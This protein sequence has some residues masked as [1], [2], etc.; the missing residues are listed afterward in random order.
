MSDDIVLSVRGATKVYPGTQALKGVDFDVRRGAV[1]VLVGENGAGKSTLMKIIAGVEQ[2]TEGEIHL[3]GK[4]VSLPDT[5]A[6]SRHGIGIVFQE[7]NLFPN[8]S[9]ADN[10]FIGREKTRLGIDIDGGAQNELARALLARLEHSNSPGTMVGDLRIGEQQI[11][12]IAK[13]LSQDARILILDEPTS[14][15]S[16]TEVEIL[17][18]VI[19]ELKAQGVAIVY[20]SHRLEELVRIGDYITVLRDGRITGARGM[21]DVDVPWIVRAMIGSSS[22]DFAKV[23]EHDYGPEILR[24]EDMTLP[25][26]GGGFAVDHVSLS[27]RSG[28]IVGIYGLMGAGRTELFDCIMGREPLSTGRVTLGGETLS[29]R[30]IH[31]RIKRGIALIPEDRKAE[32]LVQILSVAENMSMSSLSSFTRLFHLDVGRER[33]SV[34]DF[35][36]RLA[37]KVS[38]IDNPVSSLSGGNQQKI[39]IGKALMTGPKVLLMDEPSRGIDIGAKAEVFRVMRELAAQGLGILFV[40]SDLEEVMELSDRI[41]VMSNGRVAG[42]RH[43]SETDEPEIVALSAAGHGRAPAIPPTRPEPAR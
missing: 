28:E 24:V 35:V 19:R 33:S 6:A 42:E 17:F 37:V 14:A 26:K 16:A 3:D 1:N 8:M 12:E 18:G 11:V 4:L 9:I 7:L 15:L 29:D 39:V 10:I 34:R 2:P 32:G 20:I 41:I 13:A 40:T 38:N 21:A 25:R 5:A 31:G 30:S 23:V 27:L 36:R 22:K 43:R